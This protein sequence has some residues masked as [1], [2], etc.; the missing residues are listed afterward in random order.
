MAFTL[1]TWSARVI[2][3]DA[4]QVVDELVTAAVNATG[5]PDERVRWTELTRIEYI[6]VRLLGFETSI[7]IEVWD[8][9]P[10]P[11]FLPDD[12]GSPIKRGCYPTPRGRVVWAELPVLPQRRKPNLPPRS[13]A[14][15]FGQDRIDIDLLCKANVI[16]LSEKPTSHEIGLPPARPGVRYRRMRGVV[17]PGTLRQ[18][19]LRSLV[20]NEAT[21]RWSSSHTAELV[22]ARRM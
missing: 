3:N 1:D 20:T 10:N 4:V 12:A 21:R 13:P 14:K 5:I 9:A 2:I 16:R 15:Q 18:T 7:R 17:Q 6:T 22:A 19:T 8:S 11:P